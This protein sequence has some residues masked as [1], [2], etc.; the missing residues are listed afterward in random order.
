MFAQPRVRFLLILFLFGIL[1]FASAA[2]KAPWCDEAYFAEPAYQLLQTGKMATVVMPPSP[3][4]DP[5]TFGTDRYTFYALPLDLVMQAGWYRVVGFGILQMRLLSMLWG[6][7]AIGAWWIILTALGAD[8]R[9]R[10]CALAMVAL[11]YTFVRA[12]SDGRMDMMS[13]ALGF[14]GVGLFLRVQERSYARASFYG[15]CCSAASAFTHPIGGILATAGLGL[16]ILMYSRTRLRWWHVPLAAAPYLMFAGAWGL[17]IAQAPDVF[18]AQFFSVSNGR[19]SAWKTPLTAIWRELHLRWAGPFG[20]DAGPGVKTAKAFVLTIYAAALVWG[21]VRWKT[22]QTAGF[23][24]V[25]GAAWLDLFLLCFAEG[26]KSAAYL[27]HAVPW[28]AVLAALLLTRYWRQAGAALFA[29]VLGIQVLGTA[30]S[31]S[32]LQYQREYLPAMAFLRQHPGGVTGV[33]ELGFA[34]GFQPGLTD[35]RRLGY[36]SGKRPSLFVVDKTY[37]ESYD[38]Y[39]TDRPEIYSYVQEKLARSRLVFQNSLYRI[40][41]DRAKDLKA[42]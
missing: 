17:Y 24:L 18:R 19:L 27:I 36:Y 16:A 11:D 32:R 7:V 41:S 8:E 13:A 37:E 21:A 25:A 35:D 20:L 40:Y 31:A 22:V 29:A 4:D 15:C 28:M 12:G 30:Y 3:I 34:L 39:R 14:L 2:T 42:L 23:G 6:A 1:A 10:W 33:A 5:K 38:G 26:T 9:L